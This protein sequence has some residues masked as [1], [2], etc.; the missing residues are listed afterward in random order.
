[1]LFRNLDVLFVLSIHFRVVEGKREVTR[2]LGH[3]G[4]GTGPTCLASLMVVPSTLPT[5]QPPHPGT[6]LNMLC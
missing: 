3:M 2:G 5:E 6:S 4:L 1:M